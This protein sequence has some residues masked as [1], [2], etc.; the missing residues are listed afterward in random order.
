VELP[1]K[2]KYYSEEHPLHG[3]ES[4]EIKYMTAKE[5][6]ILSSISL[7]QKGVAVDRMLQS[8][9]VNKALVPSDML[10]GDKNALMVAARITG[11]GE[12]YLANVTCP[13]CSTRSEY[14]FNLSKTKNVSIDDL[15]ISEVEQTEQN[16]F[17]F[18]L[19]V[20]KVR[21]EVRLLDGKDEQYLTRLNNSKKDNNLPETP[22]TDRLKI[23]I[24]SINGSTIRGDIE[25]F[26]DQ[27]PVLDSRYLRGMYSKVVP[28]I[29]LTQEFTCTNCNHRAPMEVPL[30]V[31][32]FWPRL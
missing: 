10:I 11:F 9:L 21:T 2:G 20:S 17:V 25:K 31:D 28:N 7:L 27:M 26:V 1:S 8:L 23:I 30:T 3:V 29:D 18:D 13:A 24:A 6:D 15:D 16:T 4:V 14:T 5:E 12:E 32:F 22:L 19:P